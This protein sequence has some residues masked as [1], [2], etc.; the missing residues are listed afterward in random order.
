MSVRIRALEADDQPDLEQLLQRVAVFEP[1]E[2]KVAMELVTSALGTSGDYSIYVAE[3]M[4]DRRRGSV[5]G[6]PLSGP[7]EGA[8][9]GF[10]L[11]GS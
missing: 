8:D 9:R 11:S 2:I 10:R 3:E 4:A 1:H 6:P 5:P 7:L